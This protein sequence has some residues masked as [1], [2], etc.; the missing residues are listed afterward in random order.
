MSVAD[1]QEHTYLKV[2]YDFEY[3]TAEG[4]R[5]IIEKN[6]KLYL[7]QK[8]NNDWWQAVRTHEQRSFYVPASYVR[9]IKRTGP[10]IRKM[11][12]DNRDDLKPPRSPSYENMPKE[13]PEKKGLDRLRNVIKR[14][15]N[16][17]NSSDDKSEKNSSMS[18]GSTDTDKT[19]VLGTISKEGDGRSRLDPP[20]NLFQKELE[21]SL[22]RRNR[23]KISNESDHGN[24]E[25]Q[26]SRK[27]TSIAEGGTVLETSSPRDGEATSSLER[28]YVT[29][30]NALDS[31]SDA[32]KLLNDKRKSWAIE[33][34]MS[35]LSQMRRDRH[36]SKKPNFELKSVE[37]KDTFDPL[38]KL[39]RELHEMSVQRSDNGASLVNVTHS[40]NSSNVSSVSVKIEPR[41]SPFAFD[42]SPKNSITVRS[43]RSPKSPKVLDDEYN[44][45]NILNDLGET[46]GIM[47]ETIDR[48]PDC[49]LSPDKTTELSS[50]HSRPV[51]SCVDNFEKPCYSNV[52]LGSTEKDKGR[53]KL[54]IKARNIG[55]EI[56]LTPSLEK[57]A[58]EI[59]FLPANRASLIV[60]DKDD[61][62]IELHSDKSSPLTDSKE[63][64][65]S[66]DALSAQDSPVMW[67]KFKSKLGYKGSFKGQ[68]EEPYRIAS[69]SDDEDEDVPKPRVNLKRF[70]TFHYGTL[71]QKYQH[72]KPE[73]SFMRYGAE[74]SARSKLK[75]RSRSLGDL[76]ILDDNVT[77]VDK[78]SMKNK[79]TPSPRNKLPQLK[80]TVAPI[81]ACTVEPAKEKVQVT[82]KPVP[83]KRKISKENTLNT[84]LDPTSRTIAVPSTTISTTTSSTSMSVKVTAPSEQISR[85]YQNINKD[86]QT[87]K[88]PAGGSLKLMDVKQ[89]T[90]VG[91]K[92][93]LCASDS[94]SDEYLQY[95]AFPRSTD[96][97][98]DRA[99]FCSD[100]KINL[101]KQPNRQKL[102]TGSLSAMNR[103]I[104]DEQIL[105]SNPSSE[106]LLSQS[107]S[108]INLTSELSDNP[109][110]VNVRDEDEASENFIDLPPGWIQ[111]FD[112]DSKQICF[113]NE[114][115]DKWFSSNDAEGKIY[116]FEQNSNES[117]WA[118]PSIRITGTEESSAKSGIS[119]SSEFKSNAILT[120]QDVEVRNGSSADR[121][122]VGK[123]RSMVLI[124]QSAI[125]RELASRKSGSI[126]RDW[127]QLFDGNMCVLKEGSINRT[128]ITEN[129][130][131]L[132]KNWSTSH[133]VLTELFLLFFKDAKTFAAMKTG[134]SASAKPDI[135]VDLNGALVE[136]GERASSRK[137]V[138]IISTVLGL[139]VLIQSDNATIAN[140]WYQEIHSAISRLPSG[141]ETHSKMSTSL[142]SQP[143]G[144][145]FLDASSPEE[146][147]RFA[148]IGR[149][150]SVK[151]KRPDGSL[152]DLSGTAAER[153]TRIKAKL[154]RFF[155][156]RPTMDSL[157]K[158]GIY[159]DEPAF[160]SY[161][162]DV[163][164]AEPPRIPRFVKACIE[165]LE[166]NT[167]NMKTDGLYRASGNLSQIQKIRLQVDQNNFDVLTQ[168][169][170]VHVL[171][172]ALKLFFRE[173]KEPLIPFAFFE[174]A[175]N[176]SM[177]KKRLEKIQ[178]FKEIVKALPPANH[179]T[180][181]FLL[182]HLLRV[183]SYQE[184]N[185]MHIPNLAIVFGPTLMWPAEESANMALDLMQQNLVIECLLSDYDRIF[186]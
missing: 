29:T 144:K 129:G 169:E 141:F 47:N 97:D 92:S 36:D 52:S 134:Q 55:T 131:K 74:V 84:G 81:P 146:S 154:R 106:A 135:S 105:S 158:N 99:I 178:C 83:A 86:N 54:R 168:E 50:Y 149:S 14:F 164:P 69:K 133:V 32:D 175:L 20:Q 185:R 107:G 33:E 77:T 167:E 96:R 176:A 63:S 70:A 104:S 51:Q 64:S 65:R 172:G 35:E 137:N 61:K 57:L 8:T 85:S 138:Y 19:P 30:E 93:L 7:L 46:P 121:V 18:D 124:N 44:E 165:V 12:K 184:Y 25:M 37:I 166:N 17:T 179:D 56:K 113:I 177:S 153:Q 125:S 82:T 160:G 143:G 72:L 103:S 130:K 42:K 24:L 109:S 39:T 5:V 53:P 180:L 123:T 162:S 28:K 1:L 132:R 139:Q 110:P 156:R 95:K 98:G 4:R 90:A 186:K 48:G 91:F 161:L 87:N 45:A 10:G 112:P 152:E 73:G 49:S 71:P 43:P 108:E 114:R 2:L 100:S 181:Q 66:Q 31:V 102:S 78:T 40:N 120:S 128:K 16:T 151:I 157:V 119:T 101:A 23:R 115:G 58:S 126:P 3:E 15:S 142:D 118:L 182:Q 11:S 38:D 163:C 173:L 148:K 136:P 59:Q 170:D 145:H 68:R 41:D 27:I 116:F 174:R 76:K 22:E 26:N 117:S 150:R 75:R 34:L 9:E 79:P 159:K 60:A 171:T 183:T 111:K 67:Q 62:E 88:I 13:L 89:S 127:P 155:Q 140:E 122:R 94:G 21:S 6:E 80:V 147:K